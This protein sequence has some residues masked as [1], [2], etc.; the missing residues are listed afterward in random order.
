VYVA[1]ER[2]AALRPR[3]GGTVVYGD[4]AE[5]CCNGDP[6]LPNAHSQSHYNFQNLPKILE[7][8]TA[9]ASAGADFRSWRY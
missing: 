6:K 8:I 4:R 1:Q 7:R 2:L 3:Y 9:S 5:H